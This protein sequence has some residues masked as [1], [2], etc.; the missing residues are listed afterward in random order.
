ME[1][2]GV[3][4][5][6]QEA[7]QLTL[8]T[9]ALVQSLKF[10]DEGTELFAE[11]DVTLGRLLALYPKSVKPFDLKAASAGYTMQEQH[12]AHAMVGGEAAKTHDRRAEPAEGETYGDN[13]ELF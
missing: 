11:L 5:L 9:E 13:V 7:R 12:D 1:C 2:D 10:V 3:M 4:A 6:S 8:K